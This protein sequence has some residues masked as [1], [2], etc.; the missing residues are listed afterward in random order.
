VLDFKTDRVDDGSVA[1]R[2][3]LYRPQMEG[4]RRVVQRLTGLAADAVECRLLFLRPDR[5]VVV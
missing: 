4:Y 1:T 2:V 3:E 5:V